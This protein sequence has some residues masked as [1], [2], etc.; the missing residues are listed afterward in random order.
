M[1]DKKRTLHTYDIFML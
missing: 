1:K